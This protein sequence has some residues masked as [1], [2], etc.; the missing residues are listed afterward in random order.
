MERCLLNTIYEDPFTD[1]IKKGVPQ[2]FDRDKRRLGRDWPTVAHTM[3]GQLRLR[4][5]RDLSEAV[6]Q[7]GIP[8]DFIETGVWRG[9][10][11]IMFR[12]ILKAYED[13]TRRVFVAD[14]FEGLPKPNAQLYPADENDKHHQ[15]EALAVSLEEVQENFAK[16]ALLDEQV[17]FLKGWF[18]DTLP[19][20]PVTQIAIL[21]LD[22]DMYESTMD[23]L[24]N[25]Y[26][27]VT[28]GGYI[29]VDDYGAVPACRR[30][31]QDFRAEQ[32]ISDPMINIDGLGI[33]WRKTAEG[34][35]NRRHL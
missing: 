14:S 2:P 17:V 26:A 4:N 33:Y 31:I 15:F 35:G 20:A 28:Q 16:Y 12:A 18:K 7:Q 27:K 34:S 32:A 1:W 22:G 29:I 9:G 5:L 8:G 11:C 10:A 13:Q 6:I 30:A 3:I 19:Q 25:L 24:R 23:G 21:R